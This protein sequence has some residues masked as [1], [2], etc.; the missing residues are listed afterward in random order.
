MIAKVRSI[1]EESNFDNGFPANFKDRANFGAKFNIWPT[2][3]SG[4]LKNCKINK[5]INYFVIFET[6]V[7]SIY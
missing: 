1:F 2:T 5:V 3:P 7:L 4:L 6:N